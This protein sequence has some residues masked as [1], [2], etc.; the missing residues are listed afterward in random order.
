MALLHQ[1]NKNI[2]TGGF[3]ETIGNKIKTVAS[4][5]GSIKQIYDIG[6]YLAPVVA[7][8]AVL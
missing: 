4:I 3:L 5:A 2:H 8:A 1:F 7:T 6:R